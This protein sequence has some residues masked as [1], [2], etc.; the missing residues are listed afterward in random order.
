[1]IKIID[2]CVDCGL[3]CI[4]E[5]CKYYKKDYVVCDKCGAV[6]KTAYTDEYDS[7]DLCKEC[8]ENEN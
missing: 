6:I 7:Y 4:F 5:A 8:A 3:P 2:N 1:M